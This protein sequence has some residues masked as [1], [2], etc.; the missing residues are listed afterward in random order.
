MTATE[1]RNAIVSSALTRE[2]KNTYSQD[3]DKRT[4]I[5]SGYG[6]CSGTTWYWYHKILG[7]DIGGNTQAQLLSNLGQRVD[8]AITNGIPDESKMK[9]GDLLYFRG[10]DN[11][12]SEGVGHVEMYIGDGECFGHGSGIGGTVKDMATYCRTRYNQMSTAKL[13]NKGLICVKRF[14]ADDVNDVNEEDEPMT[15]AEKKDFDTLTATVSQLGKAVANLE[16]KMIYNYVDDNMP[17]WARE[18]IQKLVN[19]G[20]IKG[21]EDGELGLTYEMIK[22][23][24]VLERTGIFDK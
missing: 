1:K 2:R 8:L 9:K 14:I 5:E 22:I 23:F 3:A 12:R 24:V 17:V 21:N 15:V 16:G 20:F 19:K 6:D 10:T 11:S 18:P 4:R 13:R 7:I